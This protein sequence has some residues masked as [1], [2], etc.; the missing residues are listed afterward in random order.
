M[1]I[2]NPKYETRNVKPE[3]QH[4][5][6]RNEAISFFHTDCLGRSSLAMTLGSLRFLLFSFF[7]FSTLSGCGVYSFTGASISPEVKSV[8]IDFFPSYAAL[9]PANMPQAFTEALRDLFVSRTNLDLLTKNGDIQFEGYISGYQTRPVAIQGNETAAQ[10]RLTIKVS[11]TYTSTKDEAKSFEKTFSRFA[12][13]DATQNLIDVQDGL[14]EEINE[15]LIL[16]IFNEAV[17]NW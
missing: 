17:V 12:D 9:A 1:K 7:L 14:I 3:T 13:F 10:N 8:S 15:Q 5:I 16:D 2:Q 6:A 11:V 4:V